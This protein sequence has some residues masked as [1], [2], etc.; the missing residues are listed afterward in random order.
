MRQI[1][2]SER[3]ALVRTLVSSTSLRSENKAR[4]LGQYLDCVSDAYVRVSLELQAAFGLRRE[5][6]LK[7][8]PSYA[9][10]GDHIILKA[11][12]T[13]GSR[14]R[15]VPITTAE[16][17]AVLDRET[18]IQQRDTYDGQ[19]QMAGLNKMHGLR[20]YYAQARYEALTGWKAPLAGGPASRA[21]TPVQRLQDSLARKTI[22]QELGHE[23]LQITAIYLAR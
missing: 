3:Q 1:G 16:Q 15:V 23:R 14:A 20:H 2:E 6:C 17:C 12:W 13:K 11:S 5:E 22:S 21:L 8:R 10:Q 4:Q 19:C 7:F 9:D 18:Y